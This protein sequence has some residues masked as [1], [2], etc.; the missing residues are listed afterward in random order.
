MK[1]FSSH[2][3]KVSLFAFQGKLCEF[4]INEIKLTISYHG[5]CVCELVRTTTIKRFQLLPDD[6]YYTV[7][8]NGCVQW[9]TSQSTLPQH[10]FV[11][12]IRFAGKVQYLT[13]PIS[14]CTFELFSY[15]C[16]FN[17]LIVFSASHRRRL[18]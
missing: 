17:S 3:N 13:Y 1:I 12:E 11:N 14:I 8:I 7:E 18:V 10:L 4:T 9:S 16:R 15:R 2:D 5:V 6:R